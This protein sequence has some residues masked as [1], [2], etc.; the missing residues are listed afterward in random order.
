MLISELAKIN[1]KKFGMVSILSGL[2]VGGTLPITGHAAEAGDI[3]EP[4]VVLSDE[5]TSF[6]G[7]DK[8]RS[9]VK[10]TG[11]LSGSKPLLQK[12]RA[13]AKTS[14]NK[15]VASIRAKADSNNNGT[16]TS[17]TGW[18]T[19]SKTTL[20]NSGQIVASTSSARFTGY[21]QVKISS[22]S[23]WVSIKNTNISY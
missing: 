20:A 3:N 9:T 6:I 15:V 19:L 4:V 17:S 21:H 7:D 18:K 12:P 8:A 2:L 1:L 13:T 5:T 16:S 10:I 23:S 14:T 22:S 11:T